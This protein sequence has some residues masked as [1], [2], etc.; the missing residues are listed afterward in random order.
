M[1]LLRRVLYLLAALWAIT[2]LVLAIVPGLALSIAGA[3]VQPERV[4]M[5]LL[6]IVLV[7]LA[8]LAVLMAQKIE[9]VWWWAWAFVVE[10][11]AITSFAILKAALFPTDAAP[12]FWWAI[13]AANLA[14]TGALLWALGRAGREQPP[15]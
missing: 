3:T 13:A 1:T 15:A 10:K 7:T 11:A 5:R 6:G 8:M 12:W 14:L 9:E 2:G 4:W